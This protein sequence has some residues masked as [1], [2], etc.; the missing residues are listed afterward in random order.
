MI[1]RGLHHF[2]DARGRTDIAGIDAQARGAVLRRLDRA[3][4]VEVDVRDDR[5][6]HLRDDVFE[7][8]RGFLVRAGDAHDIGAGPLQRLDLSYRRLDVMRQR[9]G[10][11]LDGDRR[12]AAD[13]HRADVDLPTLPSLDVAIRTH[14]HGKHLG[15]SSGRQA[16]AWP[17]LPIAG[18]WRWEQRKEMWNAGAPSP[19]GRRALSYRR[20]TAPLR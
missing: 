16:V 10:H 11:R 7:G 20:M 8:C 9:V 4:V 1:L 13:R 3:L 2:F 12:I 19:A 18:C 5:H 14:A 17:F 15:K 6:L